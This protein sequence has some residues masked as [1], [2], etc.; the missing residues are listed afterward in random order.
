MKAIC[1][2]FA[3]RIQTALLTAGLLTSLTLAS[4]QV[5]DAGAAWNGIVNALPGKQAGK[6]KGASRSTDWAALAAKAAVF[7]KDFPGSANARSAEAI[8]LTALIHVAKGKI[9]SATRKRAESYIADGGNA[10]RDRLGLEITV[11]QADFGQAQ[12]LSRSELLKAQAA[13]AQRLMSAYPKEPEGYGYQLS[14]AKAEEPGR[15]RELAEQL[16]RSGASESIKKGAQRVVDRSKLVGTKLNLRGAERLVAQSRGQ[17]LIVYSWSATDQGF[18]RLVKSLAR[19][20]EVRFIGINLDP[21]KEKAKVLAKTLGAPGWQVYD[22]GG[23][24]GLVATDLHL[25]LPTSLYVIDREGVI[26]AVDGHVGPV[27][28][29]S[30]VLAAKGGKS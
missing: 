21:D 12:H 24:D 29:L 25:V 4:G 10:V 9:T 13:H 30:E 15:G 22:G 6:D 19:G 14:V 28:R 23:L 2:L 3:F 11:V 5:Q 27:S 8:E 20:S 18:I 16:L 7:R 17:V 1:R 26:R